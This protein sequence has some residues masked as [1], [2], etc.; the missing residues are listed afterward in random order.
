MGGVFS[1][2][3]TEKNEAMNEDPQKRTS[4]ILLTKKGKNQSP[5]VVDAW[6]KEKIKES[7][8]KLVQIIENH[9]FE[10]QKKDEGKDYDEKMILSKASYHKKRRRRNL[11]EKALNGSTNIV[12][13]GHPAPKLGGK[14]KKRE[15]ERTKVR[16]KIRNENRRRL[17]AAYS[18]YNND[19]KQFACLRC[20]DTNHVMAACPKNKAS[21]VESGG[22]QDGI[23]FNCGDKG[24]NL[25]KC[26]KTRNTDGT[27]S[28]ATCFICGQTGHLSSECSQGSGKYKIKGSG[29]HQCGSIYHLVRDCPERL[30]AQ[31]KISSKVGKFNKSLKEK[32]KVKEKKNVITK[33]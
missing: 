5:N 14:K 4:S 31:K 24:H 19:S 11:L 6:D 30:Q 20:G 3:M 8:D 29:C 9:L 27:L 26:P 23:C 16:D 21:N 15:A 18:S 10:S 17:H 33:E 13:G 25:K 28:Y 1:N 12:I 2:S 7:Y 22:Y 32:K